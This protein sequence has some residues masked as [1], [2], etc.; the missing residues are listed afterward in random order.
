[1]QRLTLVLPEWIEHPDFRS[2]SLKDQEISKRLIAFVY[3]Q[4]AQL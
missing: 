3:H 1:M 2:T 4:R